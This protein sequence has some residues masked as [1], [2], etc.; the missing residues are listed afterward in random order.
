MQEK[1][2]NKDLIHGGPYK[3]T[4]TAFIVIEVKAGCALRYDSCG[5]CA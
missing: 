5:A 2:P 1:K 4:C 3:S